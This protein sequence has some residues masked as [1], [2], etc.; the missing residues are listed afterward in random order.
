M[1]NMKKIIFSIAIV[2]LSV[3]LAICA[4][5]ATYKKGDA[6]MDG[7]VSASDARLVL[8]VSARLDKFNETQTLI[9]DLSND[10]KISASDARK[11][12]RVSAKL[13]SFDD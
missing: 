8:R 11:V 9:C 5:A 13:E 3:M 2:M 12:L 7:R 6:N 1:N 10:G 4:S